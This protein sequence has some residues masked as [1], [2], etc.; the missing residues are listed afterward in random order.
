MQS[1]GLEARLIATVQA[2]L[3]GP[4]RG[5]FV[6]GLLFVVVFAFS[7]WNVAAIPAAIYGVWVGLGGLVALFLTWLF[8]PRRFG[9]SH[10]PI[11]YAQNQ[12]G[13]VSVATEGTPD[14]AFEFLA[15]VREAAQNIKPLPNPHGK[16]EGDPR[17]T[18]NLRTYSPAEQEE[19]GRTL[20]ADA[21]AHSRR[22]IE[23]V[24]QAEHGLL[25][26]TA[27]EQDQSE[28]ISGPITPPQES[29]QRAT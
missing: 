11:T 5:L 3:G 6:L 14:R 15:R 26:R 28:P 21:A 16:V 13:T 2:I 24:I 27:E 7:L 23:Q 22:V 17:D 18:R 9:Q 20:R 4:E 25:T 8:N 19:V 12:H 29:S 10:V 1:R